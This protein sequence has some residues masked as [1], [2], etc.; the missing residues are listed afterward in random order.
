MYC[1]VPNTLDLLPLFGTSFNVFLVVN[2]DGQY[3]FPQF[4]WAE[5]AR[6]AELF[7]PSGEA[8]IQR[9][10]CTFSELYKK[11][12]KGSNI[13]TQIQIFSCS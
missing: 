2:A 7:F 12:V 4:P 8:G 5:T 3:T 11:L 9:T 6:V 1:S 13:F 10:L